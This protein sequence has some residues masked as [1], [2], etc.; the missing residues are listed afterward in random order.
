MR[1]NCKIDDNQRAI[2]KVL[3]A[4]GAS[5]QSLSAVRKGCPDLLVGIRGQNILLEI[6]QEGAK[7]TPDEGRFH[8]SW[9]GQAAICRSPEDAIMLLGKY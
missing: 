3:Q 7:L 1:Y 8:A 5:V 2:I 9:K 6:K 4:C